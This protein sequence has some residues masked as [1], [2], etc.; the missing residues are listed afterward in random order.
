MGNTSSPQDRQLASLEAL[1][2]TYGEP[3]A[4]K[5]IASLLG[6]AEDEARA[7][8]NALAKKLTDD[9]ERGL[10]LIQSANEFQLV[11]KPAHTALVESLVKAEAQEEL[12]PAAQE[13]LAVIA[14]GGPVGR[15]DIDYVRGV[16]SSFILRSLLLRGLVDRE[17]DP[18][19]ANA[20]RYTLS[21]ECLKHLGATTVETLPDY[22]KYRQLIAKLH[23]ANTQTDE[24]KSSGLQPP[25]LEKEE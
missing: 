25:P 14:Y 4:A 3:L 13:T 9:S 22:E 17:P 24:A 7:C 19:R 18:H 21:F 1:L 16:N 10:L 2:F 8:G 5:K 15:A 12:T 11:T 23:S 6:C 20:Y